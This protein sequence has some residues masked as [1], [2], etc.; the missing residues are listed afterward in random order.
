MI[1][2]FS[3][4]TAVW[5]DFGYQSTAE[6]EIRGEHLKGLGPFEFGLE[7]YKRNLIHALDT[8]NASL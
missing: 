6:P 8:L 7:D 2:D 5:R 4:E 1:V 3:D